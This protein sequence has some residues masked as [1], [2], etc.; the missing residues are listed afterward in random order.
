MHM[1]VGPTLCLCCR[2]GYTKASAAGSWAK[3]YIAYNSIKVYSL[4][5]T[6]L[7][8]RVEVDGGNPFKLL[9]TWSETTVAGKPALQ[10]TSTMTLG[11]TSGVL[12]PPGTMNPVSWK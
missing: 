12:P 6:T 5:A 8:M 10:L 2:T 7:D 11:L 3:N 9:H 4:T 1:H